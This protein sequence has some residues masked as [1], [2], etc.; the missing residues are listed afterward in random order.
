MAHR[1]ANKPRAAT[2]A[3]KPREIGYLDP[4][5]RDQILGVA[6]VAIPALFV[7]AAGFKWIT[8]EDATSL[9]TYGIDAIAAVVTLFFGVWAFVRNRQQNQIAKVARLGDVRKI[10][11]RNGSAD[12]SHPKVITDDSGHAKSYGP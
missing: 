5:I 11:V 9:T 8:P 10:V 3:K 2:V 12:A 6:R 7:A 1:K 4:A